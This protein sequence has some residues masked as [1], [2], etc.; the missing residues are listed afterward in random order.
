MCIYFAALLE[1]SKK[2]NIFNDNKLRRSKMIGA[3]V[4]HKVIK[5]TSKVV[6]LLLI[7][8]LPIVII[9]IIK[10]INTWAVEETGSK[11]VRNTNNGY[12]F[13][14]GNTMLMS[15]SSSRYHWS[16]PDESPAISAQK[17]DR[18]AGLLQRT[19]LCI[20]Y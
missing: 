17:S 8:W 16:F 4:F 18:I 9:A 19:I 12:V 11:I 20:V 2:S 14:N 6:L 3:R 10:S 13:N 7:S 1:S 15:K 5:T